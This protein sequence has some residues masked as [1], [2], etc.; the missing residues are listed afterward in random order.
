MFCPPKRVGF[1]KHRQGAA[2]DGA[3]S[4]EQDAAD[5]LDAREAAIDE[6]LLRMATERLSHMDPSTLVNAEE[7]YAE[8]GITEEDLESC[9]DVEFE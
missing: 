9:E 4:F 2:P 1:V 8:L 6:E 5:S 7:V 3:A